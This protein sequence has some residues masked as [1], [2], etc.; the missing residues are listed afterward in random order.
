MSDTQISYVSAKLRIYCDEC[1]MQDVFVQK[2][3]KELGVLQNF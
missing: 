1:V 3:F 2:V